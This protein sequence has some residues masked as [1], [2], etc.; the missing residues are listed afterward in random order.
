LILRNS[1]LPNRTEIGDG[2]LIRVNLAVSQGRT[3]VSRLLDF[4]WGEAPEL[5]KRVRKAAA[6]RKGCS[7]Q[8]QKTA[9]P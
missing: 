7:G 3:R 9:E 8:R 5:P 2:L 6:G 4:W 1:V